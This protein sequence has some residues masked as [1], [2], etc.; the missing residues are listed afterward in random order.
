MSTNNP[1]Y[2]CGF[3]YGFEEIFHLLY[4]KEG[5][6]SVIE[7]ASRIGIMDWQKCEPCDSVTPF[8]HRTCLVCGTRL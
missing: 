5:Q 3:E 8:H 6:S 1:D 4:E 2:Q 7:L